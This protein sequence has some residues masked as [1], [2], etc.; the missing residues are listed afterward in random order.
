MGVGGA[1]SEEIDLPKGESLDA[2]P[3]KATEG[4]AYLVGGF[5]YKLPALLAELDGQIRVLLVGKV[6][7]GPNHGSATPSNRTRRPAENSNSA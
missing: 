1:L 6:D 5:G 3:R 7:G 2:S 4:P